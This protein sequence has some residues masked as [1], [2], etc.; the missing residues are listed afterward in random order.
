MRVGRVVELEDWM[1]SVGHRTAF[2]KRSGWTF[3]GQQSRTIITCA[4]EVHQAVIVS[5]STSVD[6]AFA[7]FWI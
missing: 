2:L 5:V 1:T 6:L 7:F 4:S 3:K